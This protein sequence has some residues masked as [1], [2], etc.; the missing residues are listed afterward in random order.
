MKGKGSVPVEAGMLHDAE[1]LQKMLKDIME[2][3]KLLHDDQK[4]VAKNIFDGE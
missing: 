2:E 4:Q 1:G 3:V